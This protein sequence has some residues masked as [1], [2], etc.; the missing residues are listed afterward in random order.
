MAA[1]TGPADSVY[2]RGT[3]PNLFAALRLTP[4][5]SESLT[6]SLDSADA[7]DIRVFQANPP[8]VEVSTASDSGISRI[9]L[10]LPRTTPPGTYRGRMETEEQSRSLVIEVEPRKRVSILPKRTSISAAA[11][12][13]AELR[14]CLVNLGNV[15]FDIPK[16]GGFGLFQKQGMDLA[17]GRTFQEKPVEGE[18]SIDRFMEAL[19]DGYGGVVKLKIR[20]GAGMLE[21]GDSR[22]VKLVFQIPSQLSP[23][24]SYW[25]IWSIHDYNYKIEIDV[26]PD[27]VK[28][29]EKEKLR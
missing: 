6:I 1:V 23:N 25:G 22:D 24:F 18:R 5:Q 21:A 10:R 7:A 19:R 14:L 15:P 20:E 11:G 17:V 16:A 29:A 8:V 28:N 13:M 4:S 12:A 2:M 26:L 27:E 3:P 9:H